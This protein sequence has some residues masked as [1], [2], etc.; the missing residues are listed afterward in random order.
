MDRVLSRIQVLTLD[1]VGPLSTIVEQG[2]AG[3]LMAEKA[4]TAARLALR[5]AGNTS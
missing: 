1:V 2:E 4:V 5:F 3:S